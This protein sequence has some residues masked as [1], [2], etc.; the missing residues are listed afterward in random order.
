MAS[1]RELSEM[2]TEL[3]N[4][5]GPKDVVR[6]E[7][8]IA[9]VP[10]AKFARLSTEHVDDKWDFADRHLMHRVAKLIVPPSHSRG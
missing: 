10:P 6:G 3:Y 5:Y 4:L 8:R 1:K 7:G 9:P 2:L